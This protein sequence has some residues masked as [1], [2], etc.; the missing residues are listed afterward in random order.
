[1]LVLSRKKGAAIY[2]DH[3]S[4][5]IRITVV[6]LKGESVR[7]GFEAPEEV[8]IHREEIWERLK[9]ETSP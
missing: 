3:P 1:M 7:L 2:I 8:V 4:G 6:Q 9:Q 5:P